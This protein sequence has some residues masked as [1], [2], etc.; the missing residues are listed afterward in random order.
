MPLFD[1]QG[2]KKISGAGDNERYRLL[3]SDG[4]HVNSF[5]MLAT[6]LNDKI[7]NG[8]LADNTIVRIKRYITSVVPNSGKGEK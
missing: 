5:A 6:Q 3:V 8:D 1:P 4:V 2:S 7:R